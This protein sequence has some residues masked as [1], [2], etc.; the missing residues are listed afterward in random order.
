MHSS[1]LLRRGRGGDAGSISALKIVECKDPPSV[2]EGDPALRGT[3]L[4]ITDF[5]GR[6]GAQSAPL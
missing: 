5:D 1:T 2:P 6:D 4:C 3:H